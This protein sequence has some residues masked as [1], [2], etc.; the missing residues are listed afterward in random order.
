MKIM[1]DTLGRPY[2]LH[3]EVKEGTVIQVDGG[4]VSGEEE[5]LEKDGETYCILPWSV[6]EVKFDKDI[7]EV[8]GF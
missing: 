6:L 8:V 3:S 5:A 1:T 2:A 4:F 7:F